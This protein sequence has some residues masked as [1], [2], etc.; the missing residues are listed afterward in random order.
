[1]LRGPVDLAALAADP[2]VARIAPNTVYHKLAAARAD[3]APSYPTSATFWRRGWQWNLRQIRADQATTTGAGRRV[4]VVDGG[5]DAR[6]VDLRGRIVAAAAFPGATPYAPG[7]DADGHGTHVAS[8]ITSNGLGVASVAPGALLLDAN[9]FGPDP[10]TSVAR[11]VDAL[12]WCARHE[13]DVITMSVG[14][15]RTRGTAVWT[16]DSATYADAVRAARALGAVV[17]AAA[18]NGNAA[19]PS[20]APNRAFLPREA[21]GVIAVGATAPGRDDRLPLLPPPP[22]TRSS[23]LARATPTTTRATRPR[24]RR[25]PLR[26]GGADASR[27]ALAITAACAPSVGPRVRR[28]PPLCLERRPPAWPPPT[29]RRGPPPSSRRAPPPP[30]SAARAPRRRGMPPRHRRPARRRPTLLRPRP[31]RRPPRHHRAVPRL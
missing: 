15:A 9:V 3:G 18:G 19:L 26:P 6:H 11:I 5:I 20:T 16:A 25:P 1:V 4:C 12:A 10:A 2:R 30:R 7:D 24:R 27:A 28:R 31:R 13:A 23:T 17:V 14:G 22:P 29:R 8:T 21:E